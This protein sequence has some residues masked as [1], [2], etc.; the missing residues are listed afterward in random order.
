MI[1][2]LQNMATTA[3]VAKNSEM[4]Q[5]GLA[6][7]AAP[8]EE[9]DGVDPVAAAATGFG[10]ADEGLGLLVG[11]GLGAGPGAPEGG[12]EGEEGVDCG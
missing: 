9:P 7:V 3:N 2:F 10:G 4:N 12:G 6:P 11:V 8:E 5:D 1:E